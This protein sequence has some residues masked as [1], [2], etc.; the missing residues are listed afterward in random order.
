MTFDLD[1]LRAIFVVEFVAELVVHAQALYF[2]I[3]DRLIVL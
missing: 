3:T 2:P 1:L